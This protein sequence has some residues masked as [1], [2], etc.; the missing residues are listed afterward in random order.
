MAD[1]RIYF[2][3]GFKS[4]DI[5]RW[6]S[7]NTTWFDWVERSRKRIRRITLSRKIM[8]WICYILKEASNDNKN[9]VRRWR[10]KEQISEL[11]GTR[12]YNVHGRYMSLLALIGETREVII[13]PELGINAGWRDIAFKIEGFINTTPQCIVKQHSKPT[14]SYARVV[15][16][17]GSERSTLIDVRKWASSTW[18]KAFGVN[19]YEMAG[20]IFLFEF[21]NKHMAEQILQG[22][23]NWKN[24][25]DSIWIEEVTTFEKASGKNMENQISMAETAKTGE[26]LDEGF[27]RR[28]TVV[29]W[30][31]HVRSGNNSN[32][33]PCEEHVRSPRKEMNNL[34]HGPA[35]NQK[36]LQQKLNTSQAQPNL[37]QQ[38]EEFWEETTTIRTSSPE[39]FN[40]IENLE[41]TAS[42]SDAGYVGENSN[43]KETSLEETEGTVIVRDKGE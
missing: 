31:A 24:M 41:F 5:T 23:W 7:G 19:I 26:T 25:K 30:M 16:K 32:L 17:R 13:A 2:N 37:E 38:I 1:N 10:T 18:K 39:N 8:E 11:Y 42:T 4:F 12:K 14:I 40:A 34:S 36:P 28:L 3:A 27:A 43:M 29:D 35:L 9:L 6:S 21:P 20:H 15:E 33:I 22:E